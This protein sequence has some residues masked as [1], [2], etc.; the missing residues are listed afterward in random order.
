MSKGLKKEDKKKNSSGEDLNKGVV[1][2]A[3]SSRGRQR[4][5][6]KETSFDNTSVSS[7]GSDR[8]IFERG[9]RRVENIG[10]RTN[11]VFS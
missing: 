7:C 8:V 3:R 1:S 2:E 4:T 6:S 5:S 10:P 9:S 11:P